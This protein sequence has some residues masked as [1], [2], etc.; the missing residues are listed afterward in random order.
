MKS[1]LLAIGPHPDDLEFGCGGTLI[2]LSKIFNVHLLVLTKGEVGG[3]GRN[4][5][6][7]HSAKILNASKVWWGKYSDTEVP[8][9]RELIEFYEDIIKKI[10]PSIIFINYYNDTHQDHRSAANALLSATRYTKNVLFYEVPTSIDFN[11][12]IFM[13]IGDCWE[14]KIKLLETHASQ[15]HATRVSGLS[16][17][18]NAESCAIF[19]GFQGRVKYAEGFVPL[20]FS[21]DWNLNAGLIYPA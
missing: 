10:V 21:L 17:T 8:Y 18:E 16:I 1:N 4:E 2:K 7:E 9:S 14:E 3:A 5:E 12:H 20:R 11:P 13:D 15:I 6:Q 19:R